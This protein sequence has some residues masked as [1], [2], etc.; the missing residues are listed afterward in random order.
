MK[1]ASMVIAILAVVLV[2]ALIMGGCTKEK[3]AGRL[4]NESE[5]AGGTITATVVLTAPTVPIG[6]EMLPTLTPTV[7][8]TTI[9][10]QATPTPAFG[11]LI[12]AEATPTVE[13]AP[14]ATSLPT[15]P[16]VTT[17]VPTPVPILTLVPIQPTPEPVLP[18]APAPTAAPLPPA[19]TPGTGEVALPGT[20]YVVRWG[21]TL[22]SIATQ[23]GVTVEAIKAANGLSGDIIVVGQKLVIPV[24]T[25]PSPGTPGTGG[26]TITHIVQPGEN[27]FRI[28]LRYNT[29]VE[30]ISRA[31]GISNPWFI[32]V[33][34]QLTIPVGPGGGNVPGAPA[35]TYVVQAGDTLYM[36]AMRFN[37]TIQALMVANNLSN[38]NTIYVG[39]VLVLP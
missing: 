35:K 25:A 21:D 28:A 19:P 36:I 4:P 17:P 26:T 34:Q 2:A 18:A 15:V 38:P 1:R 20:V 12:G 7:R 13:A 23:F 32:Y 6:G 30:A 10:V 9:A 31:N 22:S 24:A 33:G 27:L 8:K 5:L 29:T 39:Q 11:D 37:T 16:A 3:P 14:E